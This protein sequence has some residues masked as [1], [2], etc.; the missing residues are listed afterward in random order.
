MDTTGKTSSCSLWVKGEVVGVFTINIG[1]THS[2]TALPMIQDLLKETRFSIEDIDLFAVSSGPGSFTGVR[3]GVAAV[4]GLAMALGK[5]CVGISTLEGLAMNL[6]GFEGMILPALDARRN[7][8][9]GAAFS[10]Q[11]DQL[12][13]ILEEQAGDVNDFIK[14]L[15]LGNEPLW[16][17]GDGAHILYSALSENINARI[18]PNGLRLQN[19]ASVV[20]RAAWIA[21]HDPS[22][23]VSAEMLEIEYLRLSQAERE[24]QEKLIEK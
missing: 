23:I 9:Y 13:R 24:R 14:K 7:Q 1:L 11:K 20:R 18:V 22:R 15:P 21:E 12:V 4:K 6:E 5:P 2:E 19:A 8:I 17:L 10:W 16:V 3:I